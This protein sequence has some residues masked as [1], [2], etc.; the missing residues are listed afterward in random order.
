MKFL[1]K[2]NPDDCRESYYPEQFI[3]ITLPSNKIDLHTFKL[4]YTGTTSNH[5]KNNTTNRYV[6]R[7][8][9][10]LSSCIIDEIEIIVNGETK[11]N[12]REYSYLDCLL[13]D[14]KHEYD[15]INGTDFDTIQSHKINNAGIIE[16]TVKI[17]SSLIETPTTDTFF[18]SKWLGFLNEGGRYLDCTNKKVQIRIK[19]SPSHILYNGIHTITAVGN[20]LIIYPKKYTLTN[21][22]ATVDIVDNIEIPEK[23]E[24]KDYI[25]I[26]GALETVSKSCIVSCVTEK[27]V[28]WVM[29]TF[30]CTDRYI[31]NELILQH[32]HTNTTRYGFM[33]KDTVTIG[34]YN[35]KI[36]VG[37]LYSY[38]V[39]KFQK[40][41]YLLNNSIYYDRNGVNINTCKWTVNNYDITPNMTIAECY[42]ETKQVFNSDFKK[43][44]SLA[45]F[46]SNFFAN[47]VIVDDM[48]NN[49]KNISWEVNNDPSKYDVGGQPF[50]FICCPTKL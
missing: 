17:Q 25:T 30:T 7:F 33:I 13:N 5:Y 48:T 34:D 27:P 26:K 35:N 21:V 41:P 42:N 20:N 39:S 44:I 16:N 19:L 2:I 15:D 40:D 18:I 32:A 24:F 14:I 4:Y 9:P 38:E 43:V 12:I 36:P 49:I 6:K 10:R 45:S 29:G 11:Q 1:K 31:D 37:L 3:N 23:F 22:Y 8:F 46:E 50:I 47:A 28:E